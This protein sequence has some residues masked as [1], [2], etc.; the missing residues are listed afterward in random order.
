MSNCLLKESPM[1]IPLNKENKVYDG[2]ITALVSK[3]TLDIVKLTV[4]LVQLVRLY[5]EAAC[6]WYHLNAIQSHF[7]FVCDRKKTLG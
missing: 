5:L 3:G 6:M 2:F 4:N 7:L 1:I